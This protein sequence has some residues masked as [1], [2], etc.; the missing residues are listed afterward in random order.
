MKRKKISIEYFENLEKQNYDYENLTTEQ[1]V[2]KIVTEQKEEYSK[3][4]VLNIIK[5]LLNIKPEPQFKGEC[6]YFI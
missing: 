2:F 6:S 1:L 5:N 3:N 4:E